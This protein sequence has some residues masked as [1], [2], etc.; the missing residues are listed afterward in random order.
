[1]KYI[2]LNYMYENGTML[3]TYFEFPSCSNNLENETYPYR[4]VWQ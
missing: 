4:K 3:M 1:M 2:D